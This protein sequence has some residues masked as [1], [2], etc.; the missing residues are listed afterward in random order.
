MEETDTEVLGLDEEFDSISEDHES[1]ESQSEQDCTCHITKLPAEMLTSIFVACTQLNNAD[2]AA[3]WYQGGFMSETSPPLVFLAVCRQWRQLASGNPALWSTLRAC[4]S[5]LNDICMM[6]RW[7]RFADKQPLTIRLFTEVEDSVDAIAD[8]AVDVLMEHQA[9]WLH[10]ELNW[11]MSDVAPLLAHTFAPSHHAPLLQTFRIFTHLGLDAHF[12][13]VVD[14]RLGRLLAG[15]PDL[16]AFEWS[17]IVPGRPASPI[18]LLDIP[19]SNLRHLKLGCRMVFS[20]C[21]DILCRMPFLESCELVNVSVSRSMGHNHATT[22][23][24]RLQ[25][26]HSLCIK[27]NADMTSFLD[28]LVLPSLRRIEIVFR[29]FDVDEPDGPDESEDLFEHPWPHAEFLS[30]LRRSAC[31]LE[32]L[33]LVTSVT[34]DELVQYLSIISS[35]LHTLFLRGKLGWASIDHHALSV[36]TAFPGV[37]ELVLCPNLR[38]IRLDDCIVNGQ[39]PNGCVADMIQSRLKLA[40]AAKSQRPL[41]VF[42]AAP[43]NF[44]DLED[45]RRLYVLSKRSEGRL[46][47]SLLKLP[48]RLASE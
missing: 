9:H 6:S 7:L 18:H 23:V 32:E 38:T 3:S 42:L 47:M 17:Y 30:F 46:K 35:T 1:E 11:E 31:P 48:G 37:A 19:F 8:L 25:H 4:T 40:V 29:L 41:E 20:C 24:L 27:T 34:E 43:K 14:A 16:R 13:N 22:G 44:V 28:N 45:W 39:L 12:Q 2:W 33:N 26:L 5:N 10:V 15:S 36:L 21:I